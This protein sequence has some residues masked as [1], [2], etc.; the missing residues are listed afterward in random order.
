MDHVANQK[1]GIARICLPP[2]ANCLV[3]M[4]CA[5]DV[6]TLD[7]LNAAML[8]REYEPDLRVRFVN[9]VDLMVLQ[10]ASEQPHG[11]DDRA[12]DAL[13]TATMPVIFAFHGCASPI[14][15]LAYRCRNHANMFVRGDKEE[16]TTTTPFDMVVPNN[17]HRFQ[18][19][20]DAIRR[21]PRLAGRVDAATAR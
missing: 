11:L 1:A 5:G 7:A 3:V 18:L 16:G 8:L 20:L 19:A 15:K 9:V 17:V 12:F 2:D 6:P 14:H 21:V 4:A 10:P 13:F